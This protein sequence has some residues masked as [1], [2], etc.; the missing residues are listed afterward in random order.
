[1]FEEYKLWNDKAFD[2]WQRRIFHT[3]KVDIKFLNASFTAR[4]VILV[5]IKLSFLIK[6]YSNQLP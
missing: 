4:T 5:N 2:I 6:Q 3:N 1:M